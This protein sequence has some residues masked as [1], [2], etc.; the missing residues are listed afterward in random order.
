MGKIK[1]ALITAII[2]LL[3]LGLEVSP[4]GGS[5]VLSIAIW[6]LAGVLLLAYHARTIMRIRLGLAAEP[7]SLR[8]PG[9]SKPHLDV[10]DGGTNTAIGK[11]RF[12]FEADML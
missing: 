7:F 6:G 1:A 11:G 12:G 2:I 5:W 3:P 9:R 4:L 10:D 8:F